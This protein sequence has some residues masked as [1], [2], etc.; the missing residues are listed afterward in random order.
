MVDELLASS[1]V[2]ENKSRPFQEVCALSLERQTDWAL[3]RVFQSIKNKQDEEQYERLLADPEERER[4]YECLREFGKSLAIALSSTRF[5]EQTPDAKIEK[6]RKDLAFFVNL[7]SSVR[8]RYAEV[9]EHELGVI[10]NVGVHGVDHLRV[11]VADQRRRRHANRRQPGAFESRNCAEGHTAG[12]VS[13]TALLPRQELSLCLAAE[14]PQAVFSVFSA[15][16]FVQ[17]V[18]SAAL[19][20]VFR[21]HRR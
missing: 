6:Y 3:N 18:S 17:P 12:I 15:G 14:V 19:R 10:G 11:L 8:R 1:V 20:R 9:V 16:H 5:I 2:P 21:S 4:F 13:R 7:R